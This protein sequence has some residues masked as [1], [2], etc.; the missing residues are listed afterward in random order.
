MKSFKDFE[1]IKNIIF[2]LGGVI[3]N[4]DYQKPA[5]EFQK[6]GLENFSELY[7]QAT[8]MHLFSDLET[9]KIDANTFFNQIIIIT[10]LQLNHKDMES[11]WNSIILDFPEERI[12]ILEKL[13]KNYRIFLLSNTNKIH[14]D[15][16]CEQFKAKFGYD[17]SNLFEKAYY[18][19][20][21][22]MRKPHKEIY[23]FVLED[24]ELIPKETLF[25]EDSMQNL[26]EAG[27]LGIKTVLLANGI[28]LEG[29]FDY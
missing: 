19:F 6:L 9:G 28:S 25:V 29:F 23:K 2:D 14:Y 1:N 5:Q 21:I 17:F 8:Q 7:S 12:R 4:I 18:S 22:G 27:N 24:S 26:I 10:G 3:L 16:Y 20:K 15:L 13:R 11:A